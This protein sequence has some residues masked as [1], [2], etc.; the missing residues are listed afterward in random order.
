M[1]KTSPFRVVVPCG[2]LGEGHPVFAPLAEAGIECNPLEPEGPARKTYIERVKDYDCIVAGG[3]PFSREVLD[4][5]P[6]LKFIQRH[7]AG[8][9]AIDL[10]Y[11]A[12]LGIAVANTPGANAA[13][14]AEFALML[15]LGACH[16]VLEFDRCVKG[17]TPWIKGL[18]CRA[19]E[20]TVGL[21]G[22]GAIA[23]ALARLL[24]VFPV[25][26][27]AYDPLVDA[28]VMR[29][30]GVEKCELDDIR[31][32]AN[33]I[34]LHAQALPTTRHMIGREFLEGLEHEVIL[35]NTARG[36]LIDEAALIDALTTGK[37]VSAGLDVRELEWTSQAN[38]DPLLSLPNVIITPHVATD[39]LRCRVTVNTMAVQNILHFFAGKP[40][41][42]LLNPTYKENARPLG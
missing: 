11:A 26:V 27:M 4:Q 35:V 10:D 1:S 29:E 19:L 28:A 3:E 38:V 30:L 32:R 40:I 16:R 37:V 33:I 7:G 14:V 18:T 36:S 24:T 2:W 20:G 6:R 13:S 22:F 39:N 15:M 23:R 31:R 21:V 8:Y 5:L 12:R 17:R 25:K 34:S 9:D 42:G 41:Q